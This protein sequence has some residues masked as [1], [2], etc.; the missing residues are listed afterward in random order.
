MQNVI[1]RIRKKRVL[2][3]KKEDGQVPVEGHDVYRPWM[4]GQPSEL[5]TPPPAH[6]NHEQKTNRIT[7]EIA[8]MDLTVGAKKKTFRSTL[9]VQVDGP[10]D[11]TDSSSHEG[12]SSDE[13]INNPLLL[14]MSYQP[15]IGSVSA[16]DTST[17]GSSSHRTTSEDIQ[18]RP[19]MDEDE[20][21]V[22]V[23]S[24]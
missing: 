21:S 4:Q 23:S 11:S 14:P 7:S 2:K 6:M 3:L 1:R 9:R 18:S 13:D 15:S 19:S 20:I 12:G 17:E 16:S 22:A 5:R 8:A 10:N 24:Q